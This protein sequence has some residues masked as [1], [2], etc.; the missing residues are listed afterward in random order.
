[1]IEKLIEIDRFDSGAGVVYFKYLG[2]DNKNLKIRMSNNNLTLYYTEFQIGPNRDTIYYVG[3]NESVLANIDSVD[4]DFFYDESKE[5]FH[6]KI[7]DHSTEENKLLKLE[8]RIE[9]PSYYSFNEVF[10]QKIYDD[11][12]IRIN[13]GDIVVDIG[14]NYG[15]FS[16]YAE[17]FNPSKIISI[18]PS[19]IIFEY[20]EKNFKSGK[21]VNKAVSGNSG[22]GKF[23]DDL[24]SSASST[25]S[26]NGGYE[27]EII[28]INDLLQNLELEKIDF[29]K[30][31]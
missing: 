6:I 8:S 31:D 1:M 14:G 29:L 10:V 28:G 27:V 26:E 17:Q 11:K 13:E 18:E 20:L 23:A 7:K 2:D 24:I 16:L 15:F 25:L 30:I 21:T 3:F 5:S 9:D 22:V 12:L 4:V 19:R